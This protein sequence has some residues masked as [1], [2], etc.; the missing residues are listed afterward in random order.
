MNSANLSKMLLSPPGQMKQKA[1]AAEAAGNSQSFARYIE[2]K[3]NQEEARQSQLGRAEEAE[4]AEAERTEKKKEKDATGNPAVFLLAILAEMKQMARDGAG[5]EGVFF[6]DVFS[7]VPDEADNY[8][9]DDIHL[10]RKGSNI[11]AK[12]F[13]NAIVSNGLI[14]D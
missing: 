7:A 5:S 8:C 13:A 11:Q 6:A 4:R 2:K 1:S 10:S 14:K 3:A 9:N 12:T